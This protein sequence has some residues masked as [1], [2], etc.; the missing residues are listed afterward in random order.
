M[1]ATREGYWDLHLE[2]IKDV[3][4]LFFAYDHTNY[5]VCPLPSGVLGV[6]DVATRN[7]PRGLYSPGELRF[8]VQQT[9]SRG[10]S[11]L[12]VDQAIEETLNRSTT[13]KEGILGF[14]LR[15]DA[16]QQWML[17][18]HSHAAFEDKCRKMTT[19]VQESQRRLHKETRLGRIKRDKDD[20]KKVIEVISNWRNLI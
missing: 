6:H 8:V 5:S 4:P 2:C 7:L 17:T 3:L 10:F 13:T 11:Q 18:A 9:T 20:A 12:P 1:R 19:D 14:I 15:K 16:V